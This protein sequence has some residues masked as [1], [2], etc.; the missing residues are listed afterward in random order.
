LTPLFYF[1]IIQ[2]KLGLRS[3][4]YYIETVQPGI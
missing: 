1:W 2:V 4:F 3:A